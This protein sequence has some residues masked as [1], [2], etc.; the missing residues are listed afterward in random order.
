MTK[1]LLTLTFFV[2]T[3]F[4]ILAQNFTL[5]PNII[6]R[7]EP[8]INSIA[9]T[10]EGGYFMATLIDHVNDVSASN[11][12][13]VDA[14]GNLDASF[15]HV[16]TDSHIL[17]I[18]VL[19]DGKILIGGWFSTTN[20]SYH[21]SLIRLNSDGTID[22]SFQPF[23]IG[24]NDYV[25]S[26]FV[27]SSGKIVVAGAFVKNG[28]S[29]IIRLQSDGSIDNTFAHFSSSFVVWPIIADADENMYFQ[30]QGIYKIDKDGNT[31]NGF[32][33][34]INEGGNVSDMA[35]SQGRLILGGQFSTVNGVTR[36]NIAVINL[37]GSVNDL[38]YGP[39]SSNFSQL[40]A[41]SDGRLIV[42]ALNSVDAYSTNGSLLNTIAYNG[43]ENISVDTHDNLLISGS[44][45]LSTKDGKYP[46][47]VKLKTDLSVDE[48]FKSTISLTTG[49]SAVA[50]DRNGKILL[51]GDYGV[52]EVNSTNSKLVRVLQD[53]Q[54]DTSFH[55]EI[56]PRTIVRIVPRFDGKILVAH[57]EL[58]RLHESGL[59]DSS[60]N[61]P[62]FSGNSGN[63][64]NDLKVRSGKIF[65]SGFFNTINSFSSPG[66]VMLNEDGTVN[67]TFKS[68]FPENSY[69]AGIDF[70]SDNKI[71]AIGGF[72]IDNV[73]TGCVRLNPDGSLDHSF[74]N[75]D[76]GASGIWKIAIDSKD[77]IYL[78]GQFYNYDDS[79]F[80]GMVRLMSNG[81]VDPSFAIALPSNATVSAIEVLSDSAI[82]IGESLIY[83][84]DALKLYD[85]LGNVT[86]TTLTQFNEGSSVFSSSY[87]F[88]TLVFGGRFITGD[89]Q[90]S[91]IAFMAYENPDKSPQSI[92]YNGVLVKTYGDE[93]F[94]LEATTSSGMSVDFDST[95]P[96]IINITNGVAEIRGAGT[97]TLR[98][99]QEGNAQ[100]L[101]A[102]TTAIFIV[103]KADQVIV[104]DSIPEKFSNDLPFEL[105]ASSS[106][107]LPLQILSSNETVAKVQGIQVTILSGGE[108]TLMANQ[109]GDKNYLEASPVSRVLSIKLIAGIEPPSYS[110][111]KVY[112]NPSTGQYTI[113]GDSSSQN[114]T[115]LL[116]SVDGKATEVSLNYTDGKAYLDISHLRN[117]LYIL[118][119]QDR[120]GT[121]R[122]K[123][124]K[125]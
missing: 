73:F 82:L 107:G 80:S 89:R 44:A 34:S 42:N 103:N 70:Q 52:L 28:Y 64:L 66:V 16:M 57:E 85:E 13:K 91:P 24:T 15:H 19:N 17:K 116:M 83:T 71:I 94:K 111:L 20:S 101:S 25:S 36:Q 113:I 118:S 56:T 32:S 100:Y 124:V 122:Q 37:D 11:L 68:P 78:G 46:F 119:I 31:Q 51:G 123:I 8:Y 74:N 117:G 87:H 48:K 45:N 95:D 125:Q 86:D 96:N 114:A 55:P 29:D 65:I 67:E 5:T 75:G 112:P 7:G 27:Q 93:A 9:E 72:V 21:G 63:S 76:V 18:V 41:M 60:F 105:K 120:Q 90:V 14:Q 81:E 97:V 59:K 53:G 2:T 62:V 99:Y 3:S 43:I 88:G 106:S 109:P 110:S 39:V 30:D 104:F 22:E 47:V 35:I 79:G 84:G 1:T 69:V 108:T 92:V 61:V 4:Q 54:L 98:I 115:A 33:L 49:I 50:A 102:D 58:T 6:V 77:R 23:E 10:Q 12:V 40:E 121:T 38:Q 26:F